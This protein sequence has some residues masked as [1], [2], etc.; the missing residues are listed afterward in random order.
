MVFVLEQTFGIQCIA[1]LEH[2]QGL[3]V[4]EETQADSKADFPLRLK[5]FVVIENIIFMFLGHSFFFLY[6]HGATMRLVAFLCR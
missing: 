1:G 6:S 5:T 2:N 4:A 3:W